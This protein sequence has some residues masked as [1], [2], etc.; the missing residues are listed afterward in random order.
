MVNVKRV[1]E[2]L[3]RIERA[4]SWFLRLPPDV[5][6]PKRPRLL[7]I[8]PFE[9]VR[10]AFD[11]LHNVFME[12]H[13]GNV[14][15]TLIPVF[16]M[17][18][19]DMYYVVYHFGELVYDMDFVCQVVEARR[20]GAHPRVCYARALDMDMGQL[21]EGFKRLSEYVPMPSV[22]ESIEE[23]S[24]NFLNMLRLLS[25]TCSWATEV[26]CLRHASPESVAPASL[27]TYLSDLLSAI[28][29]LDRRLVDLY[30]GI[31]RWK[32]GVV[33][34]YEHPQTTPELSELAEYAANVLNK[35]VETGFLTWRPVIVYSLKDRITVLVEAIQNFAMFKSIVVKPGW[36]V[37][38][39][40][41][42]VPEPPTVYKRVLGDRGFKAEG[43]GYFVYY[44]LKATVSLGD[45]RELLKTA[46]PAMTVTGVDEEE[47]YE[48]ALER[49]ARLES[50]L[51]EQKPLRKRKAG[52]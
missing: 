31:K 20:L 22:K 51:K 29:T 25:V 17:A 33:E 47:L 4:L 2:G 39:Y 1:H 15:K 9:S 34:L 24:R 27:K 16:N 52:L 30:Y 13:E 6:I 19:T 49:I 21:V 38:I 43:V 32:V 35:L 8:P 11:E 26:E 45:V 48:A 42:T 36:T 10:R 5:P 23:S 46:L 41:N 50:E 37:D 3:A 28:R 14:D 44:K 18:F 40:V 7:R 12:F